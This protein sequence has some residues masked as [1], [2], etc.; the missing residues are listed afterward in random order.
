MLALL[1]GAGEVVGAAL[2]RHPEI[3]QI[4]FTGSR[5][6]GCAI[7]R[8]AADLVPGQRLIKRAVIEMGGKNAIIVDDDA[9]LDEAIAGTLR[10]AFGYAGQKC[11]AAS[12]LIVLES[13][14]DPFLQRL[15]EAAASLP[16]PCA[17]T[18]PGCLLPPVI[19]EAAQSRLRHWTA[20]PPAGAN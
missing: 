2:V 19:D 10:S 20:Q 5:A 17:A 14:A 6:V 18:E 12:R 13:I 11:S 9:D 15:A 1:P 3:A 4:G 16:A 8:Q 7:L